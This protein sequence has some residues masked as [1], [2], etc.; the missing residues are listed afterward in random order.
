[1][2]PLSRKP[3]GNPIQENDINLTDITAQ[4]QINF[5]HDYDGHGEKFVVEAVASGI[6]S[7]DFDLDGWID[8]YFLNGAS[9]PLERDS[10]PS[11]ALFRNLGGMR[12]VDVTSESHTGDILFSMGVAI[13]DYN[14]DGFPDIFV[15]NF[16]QNMLYKNNGDGTFEDTTHVCKT[17]C[18]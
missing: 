15:T 10:S 12:F 16:G 7:L 5:V 18:N 14:R 11:N 6:G 17:C 3:I 4:S 2:E 13:A 1:M 8:I 9:I